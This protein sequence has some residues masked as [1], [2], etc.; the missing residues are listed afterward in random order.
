V[1]TLQLRRGTRWGALM[2]S[3][4]RTQNLFDTRRGQLVGVILSA[5]PH[6]K[7]GAGWRDRE[8]LGSSGDGGERG[9]LFPE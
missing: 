2:R 7:G 4:H 5:R 1:Y 9:Q 6:G 8:L 3:I